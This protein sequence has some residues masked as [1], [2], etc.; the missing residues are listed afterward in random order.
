MKEFKVEESEYIKAHSK[1]TKSVFY[2]KK[3]HS[4]EN[5]LFN[6]D[7]PIF[8]KERVLEMVKFIEEQEYRLRDEYKINSHKYNEATASLVYQSKLDDLL[9]SKYG[10]TYDHLANCMKFHAVF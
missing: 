1:Y 10:I 7:K 8:S 9:H 6:S 3:F 2:N 4:Q 5:I